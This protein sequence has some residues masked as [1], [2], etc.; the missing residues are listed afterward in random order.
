MLKCT[1]DLKLFV[2]Y[3]RSSMSLHY[4]Q[5]ISCKSY[6]EKQ[7]LQVHTLAITSKSNFWVDNLMHPCSHRIRPAWSPSPTYVMCTGFML[8]VFSIF[9][10]V[11]VCSP[12]ECQVNFFEVILYFL[13]IT[14]LF[15]SYWYTLKSKIDSC[16]VFPIP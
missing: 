16:F 1:N 6:F 7:I 4:I 12:I 5:N 3:V 10:M 8:P 15:L 9:F 2:L 11:S 14:K 13:A